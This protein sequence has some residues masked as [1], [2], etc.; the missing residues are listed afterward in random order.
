MKSVAKKKRNQINRRG[1]SLMELLVVIGIIAVLVGLSLPALNA[2]QKSYDSTGSE[3]MIISALST[4]R[5]LAISKGK[6]AGVRFQKEYNKNG[7]QMDADQYMIFVI[8]DEDMGTLQ[9]AFRAVEGYKPIRLPAKIGA[10]DMR[11]RTNNGITE[12]AAR[13]ASA[14]ERE[15]EVGDLDDS[16]VSNIDPNNGGNRNLI[17]SSA[18]SI[19][20]TPAGRLVIRD[21]RIRNRHGKW[22]PPDLRI[23]GSDPRGSTDT[24]FNSIVNII[25]NH[26]GQFIQDDY[27]HFGLGGEKSRKSF[28]VY[29]RDKFKTLKTGQQRFEYLDSLEVSYIN[30]YTG[31]LIE[32]K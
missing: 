28:V 11:R 21:I 12:N 24:V 1:F 13:C 19:I 17:D 5:T 10:F 6:Y 23:T 9:D 29:D 15:I 2:L 22:R 14:N 3:S 32:N 26:T 20:F 30:P 16:D 4:A 18:F 27:A 8:N 31:A 7:P 25:D